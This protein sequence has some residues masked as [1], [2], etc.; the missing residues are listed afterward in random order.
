MHN[1]V[2]RVFIG[3]VSS[4]LDIPIEMSDQLT[5]PADAFTVVSAYTALG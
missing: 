2:S 1:A 3:S 5:H 4:L